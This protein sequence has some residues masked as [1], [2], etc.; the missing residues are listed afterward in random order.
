[1]THVKDAICGVKG[2]CI[3]HNTHYNC[4]CVPGYFDDSVDN[5]G[6]CKD[7]DEC[8]PALGMSRCN[9]T[10]AFCDNIEGDYRYEQF[11]AWSPVRQPDTI[12]LRVNIEYFNIQNSD[13]HAMTGI[14]NWMHSLV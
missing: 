11:S 6:P 13:A 7:I 2:R 12:P 8:D 1:M 3:N 4:S 10:T 5:N 9:Q 14:V